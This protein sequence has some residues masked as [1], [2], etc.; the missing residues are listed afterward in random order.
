[1]R[2]KTLLHPLIALASDKNPDIQ[3]ISQDSRTLQP[4]DLFCAYPGTQTDGRHYVAE[5]IHKGAAAVLLESEI[6]NT[7]HTETHATPL[8]SII[9]LRSKLS[10]IAARFYNH[11]SRNMQLI[12]ITGTNGKSS[13]TH[14]IA[15]CLAQ[16]GQSCGLIGGIINGVYQPSLNGTAFI[17][18]QQSDATTPDAITVQK[19]L[20][21]FRE[22]GVRTVVLEVSSHGLAQERLNSLHF[23]IAGF[24][25]LTHDHLDY[26]R[27]F[28]EYAAT[29]RKLFMQP[30]LQYAVFN[31]DDA[32]GAD[33]Q[34][35]L[36]RSGPTVYGYTLSGTTQAS[37]ELTTCQA[38]LLQGDIQG[39]RARVLTPWGR[40]EL[41]NTHLI[42]IFNLY[43]LLLVLTVLGIL[44]IPLLDS[45]RCLSQLRPIRGRMEKLTTHGKQPQVII[46]YAHTPDALE[47]A[48]QTLHGPK[49][50]LW[51]IFG[52]GGN[53][54]PV[55]R[56]LMGRIA[57]RYAAQVIITQ[58]NPRDENSQD[59][60]QAILAGM[61]HPDNAIIIMDRVQAILY[62][63]QAARPED[64]III[65]GKGHETAQV[66]QGVAYPFSDYEVAE[67]A[68]IQNRKARIR[69][70]PSLIVYNR[71]TISD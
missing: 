36:A 28:A 10:A 69:P 22:R 48:L 20:A 16:G 68:L 15:S 35:T 17:P 57:E 8:I 40:G 18:L 64:I 44:D 70:L 42:G 21:Q 67:R 32:Y 46:D 25:N 41:I 3:G 39:L 4:G 12:G 2:L 58:D 63:I 27:S 11:P 45:L 61:Q 43:N 60:T 38:T 5:A 66:I 7:Y 31:Q 26:H 1:M 19:L 37:S 24:T 29:K 59:I 33:W 23:T 47:K 71:D 62:A 51:C 9:G 34:K 52:C 55:K 6:G 30:G 50:K 54:D 14:F 49:G 53:R 13:C 65:A 56:P